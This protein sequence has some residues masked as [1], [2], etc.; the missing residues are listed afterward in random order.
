MDYPKE[1]KRLRKQM[2]WSK[3]QLADLLELSSEEEISNIENSIKTIRPKDEKSFNY[4]IKLI[5]KGCE[6]NLRIDRND[7][8]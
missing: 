1:F 5:E 8:K 4:I 7:R 3:A 2:K 6:F